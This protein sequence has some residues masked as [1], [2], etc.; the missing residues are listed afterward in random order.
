MP[1]SGLTTIGAFARASGLT[2]S[3]LRFYADSGLLP[4]SIVDPVSG[5]RYY[6]EDQLDRALAIR[7]LREIGMP[8]DTVARV[9]ES[10]SDTAARLVDDHLA[11]LE[12]RVQRARERA[13]DIK[14]TL[15]HRHG[16]PV[17]TV[18]G[19]VFA[20]AV[21]QILAATVHEPDHPVLS[22]VHLEVSA[23]ALTLTATDR[24]RLSTRT[25]VPDRAHP[26]EWAATVD[27]DDLRLAIPEIRRHHRVRLEGSAGSLLFRAG[28]AHTRTCRILPDPFPDHRLLLGSLDTPRTRVVTPR[29][30]LVR[31][32]ASL[33]AHHVLL[34]VSE[35]EVTVSNPESGPGGPVDATVTGPDIELAFSMTTLYPAIGTAIG[36]DVMIDIAGAAQP[37]VIRS[38]DDGDLTTVAMPVAV[39]H[40]DPEERR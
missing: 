1:H 3:A 28:P 19:P 15:G 14:A 9:L 8:L 10:D 6:A 7:G 29:D 40:T 35:G 24:Y 33:R 17:A 26:A 2:A 12:Q 16:R 22:G 25:L 39:S 13:A 34:R 27:G 30:A 36:P 21:E 11:G 38:A 37:V 20:T 4:P 18:S 5:Y 32:L 23:E 31:T